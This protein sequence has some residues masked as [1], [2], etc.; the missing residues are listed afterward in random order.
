MNQR[1]PHA[2]SFLHPMRRL[3]ALLLFLSS[4]DDHVATGFAPPT[5][6]L[7]RNYCSGAACR[8]SPSLQII[9][10]AKRNG[11][12]GGPSSSDKKKKKKPFTTTISLGTK[13]KKKNSKNGKTADKASS[14]GSSSSSSS[15]RASQINNAS[16]KKQSVSPPW[17]VVS[18]K[19]RAKIV[20]AEQERRQWAREE[21]IH[22]ER[23]TEG[24]KLSKTFLSN[25]DKALLS[26]KRF[27]TTAQQY[28]V[29]FIGA[30]LNKQLPPRLGAPEIAFLGRS[31]VGKSS[32]LN[33]LVQSDTARVGKTPGA[34]ASVNL[35]G[36]FRKNDQNNNKAMLGL[37]DLPGFGYAKLSKD[38][39]ES[40]QV[41]AEN[42]LS[43]RKEL[44]L[45]ILLADIRRVPSDDDRAVLA[46]LYDSGVPIL[47]VATKIDKVSNKQDQETSLE[48]IRN[49]LGL[50]EGQPLHVSSI[51]GEGIK[52]LWRIIMEACE[53]GVEE[54]RT[55]LLEQGG[56]DDDA[57]LE[58]EAYYMEDG[59]EIAYSQGY[60]WIHDSQSV[61][62][63]DENGES[64]Y[65]QYDDADDEADID[66][67]DDQDVRAD[68]NPGSMPRQSI[69]DLR[70][71]VKEMEKRGDFRAS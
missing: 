38:A 40:V 67:N 21:G 19:D 49:G 20:K 47:V 62:F 14:A 61:M 26:W 56:G 58:D 68:S 48:A 28:Q 2:F 36:M 37:V 50:P 16:K 15:S 17:Q 4:H 33:K 34:T 3:L 63:E 22:A 65:L 43:K 7:Q 31:N 70:K 52:D 23:D 69:R 18:K 44:V 51:T 8:I 39:K 53:A 13:R 42:Y 5:I 6:S 71:Q 29:D 30:Y 10:Y 1:Y 60:D 64:G 57:V 41:A 45:G 11:K 27:K 32:L 54:L 9:L 55:K 24:V 59:E 66:G 12:N 25:E 35:Y 46:A